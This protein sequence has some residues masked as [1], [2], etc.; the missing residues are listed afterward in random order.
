MDTPAERRRSRAIALLGAGATFSSVLLGGV[1]WV[2]VAWHG[3]PV[4]SLTYVAAGQRLNVGHA[5]Y[6]L[7][8][9]DWA[10]ELNPPY[11]TVPLLS[12]PLV[13]VLARPFALFNTAGVEAW[14][15]LMGIVL[16]ATIGILAVRP[17][18]ATLAAVALLWN[19]IRVALDV[20]NLNSLIVAGLVAS[21]WLTIV[22]APGCWPRRPHHLPRSRFPHVRPGAWR[23]TASAGSSHSTALAALATTATIAAV[24]A[25]R[26]RP[27]L[28]F[29]IAVVGILV[30]SPV[31]NPY[32]P[33]LL[34]AVLAPLAWPMPRNRDSCAL[35]DRGI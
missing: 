6:A 34:L 3:S 7:I 20:G 29:V 4:D 8:P 16:M 31:I 12:P 13:A 11:W 28:S 18:F 22:R 1:F 35:A 25:T 10:V 5:L 26:A 27:A 23:K 9:D 15:L 19:P 2:A 30:S 33:V 21:W 32:W 24:F 17:P 14:W